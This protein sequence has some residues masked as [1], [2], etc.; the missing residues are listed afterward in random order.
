MLFLFLGRNFVLPELF[1]IRAWNLCKSWSRI[2]GLLV[3]V[4]DLNYFGYWL[5]LQLVYG[6][7]KSK[8]TFDSRFIGTLLVCLFHYSYDIDR[9]RGFSGVFG[10]SSLH[11]FSPSYSY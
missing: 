9:L 2:P 5:F 8:G 3:R 6:R 4:I 1:Q 11:F 7:G 10:F